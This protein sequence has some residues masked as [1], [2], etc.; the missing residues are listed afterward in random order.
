RGGG[1]HIVLNP[2]GIFSSVI[3]EEGGAP[4]LSVTVPAAVTQT[5]LVEP[6]RQALLR[7]TPLCA[8]CAKAGGD[9]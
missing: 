5:F 2:D 4:L 8:I 3:I 6:Q 1:Q 7:K 9:A